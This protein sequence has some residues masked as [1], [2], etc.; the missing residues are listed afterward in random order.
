MTTNSTSRDTRKDGKVAVVVGKVTDDK[1]LYDVPK[2]A[3]FFE[4]LQEILRLMEEI[5]HQL[6]WQISHYFHT[7][8]MVQDFFHQQ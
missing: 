5:L 2:A 6:I 1:R 7:S 3:S 4:K 8:Q